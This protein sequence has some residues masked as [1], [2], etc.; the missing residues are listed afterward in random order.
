MLKL[1]LPPKVWF[2][3][4]QS[5]ITGGSSATKQKP[6]AIIAWFEHSMRWVLMT[7]FGLPVEPEV[8]RNLAMVSGADLGVRGVDARRVGSAPMQI[9][10]QRG[11]AVRRADCASPRARRRPAPRP[12]WRARTASPSLAN[13]RPGVSRSM[14]DVQLAEVARHQRIGRRDRRIGDADIHRRQR[15]AARARCRCRTGS[16]SAARPTGRGAAAPARCAHLGERLRVAERAPAPSASRWARKTRSGAAL[17]Q[18]SSRSRQ[19]VR[20]RAPAP[21]ACADGWCRRRSRSSTASNAP[22]RTGRNGACAAERG[23]V[24]LDTE[25][26][27]IV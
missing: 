16:R 20:D 4:S 9:G 11:R 12:R 1:W 21:A 7:P 6:A 2:H 13:T 8:N 3:G 25:P 26:V 14:I 5:T 27:L 17:A 24:E 23:G 10:E 19:L 15:R 22:S 18:C